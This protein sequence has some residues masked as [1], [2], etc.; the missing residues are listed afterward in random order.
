MKEFFTNMFADMT[1]MT[2]GGWVLLALLLSGGVV[3]FLLLRK[4][5][6]KPFWT[7][8]TMSVGAMCM[9]LASV[10]SLIKLLPMPMGG[11]L[12]PA[13]ML[14]LLLFAYVYGTVP[15][16][17]LGAV[18]GVMQFI[19]DGG[20]A[21]AYGFVPM[22]LDYPVA[23]G[24]MGLAGLFRRMKNVRI[25]LSL[26]MVAGCIGRFAASFASGVIF[27]GAYAP[28]GWNPV[29]YSIVY[30]GTYMGAEC[31]ICAVLTLLVGERL[32]REAKK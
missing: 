3:T 14:P 5:S 10:L 21:A 18:Y 30:N 24:L 23:F 25:G 26:G 29:W 1:E 27:Y 13:S 11:S 9:A 28:E 31:I 8:R 7:A 2:V 22:L 4:K 17:T 20:N 16:L 32:A 12:T 6:G 19:L 15:G